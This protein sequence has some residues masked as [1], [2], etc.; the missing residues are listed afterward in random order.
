MKSESR[1]CYNV[2]GKDLL[3]PICESLSPLDV[4]ILPKIIFLE[5]FLV[6]LFFSYVKTNWLLRL[7]T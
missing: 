1:Q 3:L 4:V 7:K 5:N 2:V 6:K